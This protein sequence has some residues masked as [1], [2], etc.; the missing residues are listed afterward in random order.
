MDIISR[1]PG[2]SGQAAV[3]VSACTQVEMEDAPSLFNIPKSDCPDIWIRLPKHEWLISFLLCL[4]R[5]RR[6]KPKTSGRCQ[7]ELTEIVESGSL[8]FSGLNLGQVPGRADR[9]CGESIAFFLFSGCNLE[10]VC[11]QWKAKRQ[12]SRGDRCSFG[13]DGHERP[14][15][16]PKTAS[17]SEPSMTR[18]R[19]ASRKRSLRGRS[20][21]RKTNR[22]PCKNFLKGTCSKLPCD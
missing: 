18:G 5:A 6:K 17:P 12:C 8:F 4:R 20:P 21:S 14:Q 2:C 11:C 16:T 19:S 10:F 3:A 22:Q 9:N 1:L 7:D 13:H 15:P